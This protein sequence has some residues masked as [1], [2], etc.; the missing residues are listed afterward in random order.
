MGRRCT[1]FVGR[2]LLLA[3]GALSGSATCAGAANQVPLSQQAVDKPEFEVASVKPLDP[4][5]HQN[6]SDTVLGG[7]R[8]AAPTRINGYRVSI[9]NMIAEAYDVQFDQ[10]SGP[11]WLPNECYVLDARI[12]TGS[13]KSQ[14]KVMLQRLL[15]DRFGLAFHREPKQ[16]PLYKL[17]IAKGGI[18]FKPTA[19][20]DAKPL[21]L[22][23]MLNPRIDAD[24]FPII[25]PGRSGVY[26]GNY[27]S[28]QSQPL[29]AL[30]TLLKAMLSG[31]HTS[32]VR[33]K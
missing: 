9:W 17:T 13:N 15:A 33:R 16:F 27:S 6:C 5:T 2:L 31:S 25:P 24:G 11:G 8:S 7:P 32:V 1:R 22:G 10:I 20:P 29:S 28:F 26:P 18:K 30:V 19:Y 21:T 3:G 12:P 4:G 23:E 14:V